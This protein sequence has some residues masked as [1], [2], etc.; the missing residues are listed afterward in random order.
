MTSTPPTQI[1]HSSSPWLREA[2]DQFQKERAR[3]S[4]HSGSHFLDHDLSMPFEIWPE[5]NSNNNNNKK[6]MILIHGFL[7][8]PYFMRP[9][10]EVFSKQDFYCYA[11]R[12]PGHGVCQEAMRCQDLGQI[13]KNL[14]SQIQEIQT[15][16]EEIYLCG[17]SFGGLLSTLLAQEAQENPELNLKIKSLILFAPSYGITALS[18]LIPPLA[19][20]GFGNALYPSAASMNGFQNP[21]MYHWYPLCAVLPIIKGIAKLKNKNKNS[22]NHLPIFIV[23]SFEDAVVKLKPMLDFFS[24]NQNSNSR[25]YLYAEKRH[26][27]LLKA[28]SKITLIDPKNLG[29]SI[30][31]LSHVSLLIPPEDPIF[32]QDT[33]QYKNIKNK[34]NFYLGEKIPSLTL[35]KNLFR[36][37]YNPD[38][39]PLSQ[40]LLKFLDS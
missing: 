20:L 12:L 2:Q 33:S 36:L 5:K 6:A 19:A 25:L 21:A 31:N 10:A 4:H 3:F 28:D 24:L 40:A 23:G 11:P 27:G 22:L 13:L 15:Q 14:I 39:K 8:T 38:F 26:Q 17:F 7:G 37:F 18:K 35:R 30:L 29:P 16:F 34:N 1:I 9:L 32:G